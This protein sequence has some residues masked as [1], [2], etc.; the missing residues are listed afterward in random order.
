MAAGI[1][2]M[3]TTVTAEIVKDNSIK[4]DKNKIKV[5]EAP[6]KFEDHDKSFT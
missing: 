6:E 3:W 5:E 1:L 2:G 4:L